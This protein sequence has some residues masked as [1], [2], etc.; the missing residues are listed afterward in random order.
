MNK[1]ILQS[2]K[3]S[4]NIPSEL[5]ESS[6][7][8]PATNQNTSQSLSV[9]IDPPSSAA[10]NVLISQ[11]ES[12]HLNSTAAA[13][14]IRQKNVGCVDSCLDSQ[15]L[16]EQEYWRNVLKRIVAVIRFLASRGLAF[17]GD[18]ETLGST[19]NGNYLG[20]LELLS[21]FDPF[22]EQHLKQYGNAGKGSTSYLSANICEEF[23]ELMAQRL[24]SAILEEIK[25]SMYFSISVDSTP[26]ISHID[27]LTFT[28]RYVRGCE[29][30]ERF[31]AFIPI[32]SHGAK[33][34]A[35]NIVDFLKTQFPIAGANR[36]IMHPI[37][38]DATVVFKLEFVNLTSLL[39]LFP[40]LVTALIWS[41]LKLQSVAMS[42]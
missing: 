8:Y 10:E 41:E 37:C 32:F 23:I 27:Q 2:E 14:I 13:Y 4:Q 6:W 25:Q 11:S 39:C 28:I 12:V 7:N 31:M 40:A 9:H 15:Y 33:S 18:N 38:L 42:P 24:F 36:T 19:K 34:L 20:S 26:D 16:S 1:I 29:P 22:L 3:S 5:V 17:R 35:D 30:V 21:E